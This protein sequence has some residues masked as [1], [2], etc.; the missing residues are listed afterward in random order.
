MLWAFGGRGVET[1]DLVASTQTEP[2]SELKSR[3][4][5]RTWLLGF[6]QLGIPISLSGF[7]AGVPR[8]PR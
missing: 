3:G 5:L 4:S 1:P 6:S 2:E 8:I 7:F